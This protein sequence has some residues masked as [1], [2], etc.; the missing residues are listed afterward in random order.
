M[1]LVFLAVNTR[2]G[3]VT[4]VLSEAALFTRRSFIVVVENATRGLVCSRTARRL[5]T[6]FALAPQPASQ[7]FAPLLTLIHCTLKVMAWPLV[8]VPGSGER[9]KKKE[10]KK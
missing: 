2:S 7:L 8:N 4:Q 6:L 10:K 5:C 9:R 3:T 1:A